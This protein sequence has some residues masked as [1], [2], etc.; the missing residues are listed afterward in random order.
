MSDKSGG[1]QS[2][3]RAITA[4]VALACIFMVCSIVPIV[5][6]LERIDVA[7]LKMLNPNCEHKFA[8]EFMLAA[9]RLGKNALFW[10][11]LV[12]WLWLCRGFKGMIHSLVVLLLVISLTDLLVGKVAKGLWRRPRPTSV[13]MDVRAIAPTGGSPSFPSAHA[14]NWFAAA[15]ALSNFVPEGK[16]SLFAIASLVAYS[17]IYLGV[18]YPSDVIAG[19]IIGYA[20]ALFVLSLVEL[21]AVRLK[22]HCSRQA[23]IH[24]HDL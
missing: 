4:A 20:M 17:R 1:A 19:C 12:A 7:V 14:A 10:A 13:E 8:D 9:T 2:G 3:M 15:K 24:R 22:Q 6:P 5:K 16:P 21:M 18:H 11:L 23:A